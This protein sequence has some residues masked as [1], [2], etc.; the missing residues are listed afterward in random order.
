MT[1]QQGKVLIVDD[2][3]TNVVVL[4]AL[5]TPL[6]YEVTTAKNGE[7]ALRQV[8]QEKPDLVLLDVIIRC[9]GDSRKTRPRSW[10]KWF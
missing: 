10:C 5:L 1:N 7:D 4:E 9:V 6:G 2:E 8:N 3:V